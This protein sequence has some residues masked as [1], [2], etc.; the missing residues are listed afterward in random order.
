MTHLR[1]LKLF[2]ELIEGIQKEFLFLIQHF[3][4]FSAA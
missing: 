3:L 1:L 2:V 4:I